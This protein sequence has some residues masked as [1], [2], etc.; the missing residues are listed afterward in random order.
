MVL[1]HSWKTLHRFWKMWLT[2]CHRLMNYA[3]SCIT[4]TTYTCHSGLYAHVLW[5]CGPNWMWLSSAFPHLPA[6]IGM[7]SN[8]LAIPARLS[9]QTVVIWHQT[10]TWKKT[11][12]SDVIKYI[13]MATANTHT[14]M[15]ERSTST[16]TAH[17][18]LTL[19]LSQLQK[20]PRWR[21]EYTTT[22]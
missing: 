18:S 15:E 5:A 11:D 6:I 21:M 22:S 3:C 4:N 8:R 20:N 13:K 16:Q 17:K 1:W 12:D 2:T 19:P 10:H 7:I 9:I 14:T